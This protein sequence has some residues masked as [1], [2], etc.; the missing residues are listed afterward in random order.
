MMKFSIRG[1]LYNNNE[2]VSSVNAF[3]GFR[4]N[5]CTISG[6]PVACHG[7]SFFALLVCLP[8]LLT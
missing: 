2:G 4:T 7:V 5:E 8:I 3:F 6:F 1:H